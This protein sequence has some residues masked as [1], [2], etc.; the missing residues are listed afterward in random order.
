[1][2]IDRNPKPASFSSLVN[3][4]GRRRQDS[5]K[6]MAYQFLVDSCREGPRLTYEGLDDAANSV[7]SRLVAVANRGDRA[8]LL[9]PPGHEF[10]SAF[11][12]CLKA[13]IVAVPLSAP[14][15]SRLKRAL[16]RLAAVVA[17]AEASVVLTTAEIRHSLASHLAEIAETAHLQWF[18][19][20]EMNA[21]DWQ[22]T[23]DIGWEPS[24]DDIAFLQYTSGSTSAPKGV[25]VSHGNVLSQCAAMMAAS[26]YTADSVSATWMPY[27]HDYGLIEGILVPLYVGIPC[28]LM[29]PLTFIR[30]PIRW[31]EMISRYRVTHSQAPN[32]AYD[33]CVRK[34][35]DDQRQDLDLSSW[36]VAA[37]G[38]ESVRPSTL[39]D[40]YEAFKEYG[41]SLRCLSPGYGL[42]E[43]TLGVSITRPT[44]Q[45]TLLD[46]DIAAYEQGR[47]QIASSRSTTFRTIASSGKPMP[48]TIVK[49]VDPNTHKPCAPDVVGE[50][51]TAGPSVTKGYWGNEEATKETFHAYLADTDEGPFLRT[52]DLGCLKEG[53]LYITGRAKDLIIIRGLNHYP[54]DI[55]LAVERCHDAMRPG[56]GAAF[57]VEVDGE[58]ELVVVHD[59]QGKYQR[60]LDHDEVL[61]AIRAAVFDE[62]ELR[63]HAIVLL[64][65]GGVLKT[66]S[67]KIQRAGM[68]SAF[69][70]GELDS[71]AS[72]TARLDSA[73]HSV[74]KSTATSTRDWLLKQLASKTG[75]SLADVGRTSKFADLGLDSIR[76]T[77]LADE[78]SGWLDLRVD[79]TVFWNYAT[80]DELVEHL[81]PR[82]HAVGDGNGRSVSS[83][84]FAGATSK[85]SA[86]S[87]DSADAEPRRHAAGEIAIIGMGCRLPGDGDSPEAYWN[88]LCNGNNAIEEVPAD[89]WNINDYYDADA[90][91]TGKM[92]A[93]HGAFVND[94]DSFDPAFF[95]I[96]PREAK[97]IDPQQRL[98]LEVVW[99]SLERAGIRPSSLHGTETGVFVGL[100]SDDFSTQANQDRLDVH[101]HQLLGA[102]RS[103]AAGRVA[104]FLGLHGPVVQLDTACSSSLVSVYQA[105]QALQSEECELAIAGGVNLI[106]SPATMVALCKLTALAPDGKCKTFD[107]AADGYVRGEGC[108]IVVLKRMSDAVRDGDQILASIRAAVINHDGASNGLTAPNGA[109]QE[110]LLRKALAKAQLDGRELTYVEAHGTGT[111]LGDPIELE[112]INAVYGER[113]ADAPLYVGSTK[114]NIGHLEAAAGIAGLIKVVL[115]LQHREIPPHLNFDTS[116]P[117]IPWDDMSVEV[118]T[119]LRP[120]PER[121]A[122]GLAAVSSFGFSGTNAHVI[123]EA[124]GCSP[125]NGK[126]K[127]TASIKRTNTDASGLPLNEQPPLHILPLSAHCE[128]ALHALAA[129]YARHLDSHPEQSIGNICFSAS[130][131]RD[132]FKHRLA[133]VAAS[134]DELARELRTVASGDVSTKAVVGT[135]SDE[136]HRVAF[137]F[138]GQGTHYPGMGRELY[139]GQ[140]VFRAAIDRCDEV[141]RE[142]FGVPLTDLLYD[143]VAGDH[144][145][146]AKNIQPMLFSL[147]FGLVELWGSWGV[148]PDAV[149][150]H[151]MGEYSAAHAADIFD[152]E[153]GLQLVAKRGRL[154][155]ELPERGQMAVVMASEFRVQ[156]ALKPFEQQVSI[157]SING[158]DT[159]VISGASAAIEQLVARFAAEGIDTAPLNT[160]NAGHS[161]LIEQVLE[162]F[163]AAAE[164]LL[165][166]EPTIDIVSNLSGKLAN[167]EMSDATYWTRHLREPVRFADGMKAL[168][169]TGCRMFIEIGPNPNL[170]AMGMGCVKGGRPRSVW[171]PSLTKDRSSWETMLFSSAELYVRGAGIDWQGFHQP[172]SRSRVSLPTYAFQRQAFPR[173]SST[174]KLEV[175]AEARPED[176]AAVGW[177]LAETPLPD[178]K[179][180]ATKLEHLRSGL[181]DESRALTPRLDKIAACFIIAAVK[182]LGFDWEVG[183]EISEL[184]LQQRIPG[185]N[186]PKINRVFQRLEER[187]WVERGGSTYR[188]RKPAP[189]DDAET[190]LAELQAEASYPECDLLARA[191]GS[192]ADIWRGNTE[193]LSVLFPDGATDRA[194][195]FYSQAKL[196]VGYNRAAGEALRTIIES[197]SD[198]ETIRVLEVGAG[199][200]GLTTHLLP[201]VSD[202]RCEYVFTDVSPLFLHAAHD[203]FKEFR[204]L[205]TCLLDISKPPTKQGLSANSFDLVVAANVLH[206][207]PR[208]HDTLTHVRQLLKANGWL[209]LLEAANPPFWG[210]MIFTLIDGWWSFEDIELRPDY[211]LMR[212][213]R[214]CGVLGQAGFDKISCFDDAEL[215]DDSSHTLYLAQSTKSLTASSSSTSDRISTPLVN[216]SPSR[217]QTLGEALVDLF[218]DDALSTLIR[219]HAAR[220]LRLR[221]EQIDP[222]QPLSEL[223]LDSLM[224]TELRSQLGK[225]LRRDLSLNTLQMRRS[226]NEIAS[227]VQHDTVPAH[228]PAD[229]DSS[230]LPGIDLDTPRVHLVPL[231]QKGSRTPLFFVPAGYG[232]LVAFQ[233]IAHAIG[234][235]QPV[236][237]LQPASA[238]QVKTFR[239]MSIHRL[240]SAYIAELRN[241]Q[242][243]GPY[244]LSGYSAG[245]IIVV[246]LARELLRQGDEVGLLVIFDPPS[247]VPFWLDWFYS[248]TYRACQF[249]GMLALVDWLRIRPLRRLFHAFLDEGLRTHTTVTREHR[250][251]TYPGRITHFRANVSQT[252]LVSLRPVGHFWRKVARD[253][254]EVHWIPGTHYGMLRGVGASVVVDELHDCLERA[255]PK[256]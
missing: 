226:V 222:D 52:G 40:F 137:L 110:K 125:F 75:V 171:L 60:S 150:G 183:A 117:H 91:A 104:Y 38:A 77:E 45:A 200:G 241:V 43:A 239:Q 50:V 229:G 49:I 54:Q 39:L 234:A 210:D 37:N 2:I 10:L 147:Q 113:S 28:Y 246:E 166:S 139:D 223:G 153:A 106:L 233:D 63:L 20:D 165:Y 78:L 181:E 44:E 67:G 256:D 164:K 215:K 127:A 64:R 201:H 250:V 71:V 14:D 7:A 163:R 154:M 124:A 76:A 190:L 4:L 170:L 182:S 225:T 176:A 9:Y 148:R 144:F 194:V 141:L 187:G 156:E 255:I 189:V 199:T 116:N 92:Y 33:L 162:P 131:H 142:K 184:E 97:D 1:M 88:L 245:G 135:Q 62:H 66:T 13:G 55:E 69:L 132:H 207:T 47:L 90:E 68:K 204:S 138:T 129:K 30:R 188:V 240:V 146:Q 130:L 32:F 251:A 58:E 8:L 151:S 22:P 219:S 105:C 211:P 212:R 27:F 145:D 19:T 87:A 101:A 112:A 157:A 23:R 218:D 74:S 213:D 56:C 79:P 197:L 205:Q 244:L 111:V 115:M 123:L 159:I 65:P 202:D 84:A 82:Q 254:V 242:P 169:D 120:W 26:E 160:S 128:E 57:S 17:D 48:D 29:S 99:E 11:F 191:G 193:P 94:V 42:A 12:G 217:E 180:I 206:A 102:A 134:R 237:G 196:V 175:S 109:A 232:D 220:V 96:S 95:G 152:I 186:L 126:P 195:E 73:S 18:N 24:A 114:T 177:P 158:P 216:V 15:T 46:V 36:A 85:P 143:E 238:K 149:M 107:A 173:R 108:G 243:S 247:H 168:A 89:R 98:L 5:P 230:A 249:T 178:P 155:D 21:L 172:Y 224:A 235:D 231:Q 83:H 208:L 209:M 174:G 118:P 122:R 185:S 203:R 53:Q 228:L 103:I 198:G 41:L 136:Q 80:V 236:Y 93:R 252:S 119:E 61:S 140:P 35:T 16:P 31:L 192:L 51:W 161:A 253:G 34:T 221:P 86:D 227:Y 6:R 72:W 248:A 70:A 100:S 214:W 179:T 81:Q 3:L 133:I 121:D 59:I 25:M 167:Q